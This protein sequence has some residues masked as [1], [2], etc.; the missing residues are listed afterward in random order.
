MIVVRIDA[1]QLA[2]GARRIWP[3]LDRNVG[4]ALAMTA[5]LVASNARRTSLFADRSGKLRTSIMPA[6]P[7]G[8]FSRGTADV[9]VE[10]GAASTVYAPAVH[11]GSVAHE[12]RPRAGRVALRWGVSGGFRF[13]KVVRHPG[14]SPRPFMAH[15]LDEE[16]MK[17][18]R[19]FGEAVEAAFGEAFGA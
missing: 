17:F 5:D 3:A 10:A 18:E 8:T 12:I 19:I 7:T 2:E 14:T 6:A 4:T 16:S 9:A 13:A 1:R 15:A 11:D